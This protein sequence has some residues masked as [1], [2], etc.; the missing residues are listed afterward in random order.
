MT[1][2]LR[3]AVVIA[4]VVIGST[5]AL[6]TLGPAGFGGTDATASPSTVL[7]ARGNFATPGGEVE[8]EATRE[9]SDVMGHMAVSGQG[10]N[11]PWTITVDLQCVRETSDGLVMIGGVVTERAGEEAPQEGNWAGIYIERG[12]PVEASVW[13]RPSGRVRGGQCLE[14]LDEQLMW[15]RS[16]HLQ[17]VD[18]AGPVDGTIELGP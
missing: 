18:F 17:P 1:P 12:S 5:A 15:E 10:Q 4:L 2:Y 13:P 14:F 8:F 16:T 7:I 3:V 6:F 9:G 11:E